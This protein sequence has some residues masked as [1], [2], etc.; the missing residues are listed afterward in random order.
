[1][2]FKPLLSLCD[3]GQ[4]VPCYQ[5]LINLMV[6]VKLLREISTIS[7]QQ[8]NKLKFIWFPAYM[9]RDEIVKITYQQ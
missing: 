3:C 7:V 5:E 8:I 9:G 4:M 1:M 2:F 6:M